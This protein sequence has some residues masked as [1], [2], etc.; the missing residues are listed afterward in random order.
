MQHHHV[1]VIK[2][3]WWAHAEVEVGWNGGA[4]SYLYNLPVITV[5][6]GSHKECLGITI[7]LPKACDIPHN[8]KQAN[9]WRWK[10]ICIHIFK[11]MVTSIC[12]PRWRYPDHNQLHRV[13]Q[14]LFFPFTPRIHP[15]PIR[16]YKSS[17]QGIPPQLWA[18]FPSSFM[19]MW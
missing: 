5:G 8:S 19:W 16:V 9:S 17:W 6:K 7:P 1:H 4:D 11:H 10:R 3:E 14:W 15:F 12:L 13:V 18:P 2:T